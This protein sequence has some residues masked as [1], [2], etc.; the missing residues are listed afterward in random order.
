[1]ADEKYCIVMMNIKGKKFDFLQRGRDPHSLVKGND[2]P[3]TFDSIDTAIEAAELFKQWHPEI[4]FEVRQ[5]FG[6]SKYV[7]DI[8][9]F[10]EYQIGAETFAKF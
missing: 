3:A 8:A 4:N 5:Y 9:A 7:M 1:M 2:G 10:G 6:P